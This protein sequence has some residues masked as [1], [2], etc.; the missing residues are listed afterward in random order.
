MPGPREKA[1]FYIA[2]RHVRLFANAR[3][4]M[5]DL[6]QGIAQLEKPFV[7]KLFREAAGG[8]IG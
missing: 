6:R 3:C 8:A 7:Y 1:L 4:K 2:F 5:R